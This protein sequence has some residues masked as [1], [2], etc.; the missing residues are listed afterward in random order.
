MNAMLDE[1]LEVA[2][3]VAVCVRVQVQQKRV[4]VLLT[5]RCCPGEAWAARQH[6]WV[7]MPSGDIACNS[8][9]DRE[10]AGDDIY[11]QHSC[12]MKERHAACRLPLGSSL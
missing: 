4:E 3:V 10:C 8:V 11:L 6:L 2:P 5:G 12:H 1:K 9:L 7:T